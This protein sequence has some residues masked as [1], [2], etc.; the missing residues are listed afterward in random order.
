MLEF[1]MLAVGVQGPLIATPPFPCD[2]VRLIEAASTQG[3]RPFASLRE[4]VQTTVPRRNASGQTIQVQLPVT[5]VKTLSGFSR[6]RFVY[7]SQIDLACY[8]AQTERASEAEAVA[9]ML[10]KTAESVGQCLGNTQLIRSTSEEGSTPAITY[11]GGPTQPFWQV[12]I[13]PLDTNPDLV[14]AEVLILPP[15]APPRPASRPAPR[16]KRKRS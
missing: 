15:V 12:S 11:G 4:Q 5:R 16:A 3:P 9:D 2:G 13:V 10:A 6:C 1:L 8:G 14:Q 7:T